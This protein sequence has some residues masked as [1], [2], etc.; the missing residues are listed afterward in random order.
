MTTNKWLKFLPT[1][2]CPPSKFVHAHIFEY[3]K[4]GKFCMAML[5]LASIYN[6]LREISSSNSLSKCDASCE[7]L[8]FFFFFFFFVDNFTQFPNNSFGQFWVASIMACGQSLCMAMLVL[9]SIHN[10]LME[11][12]PSNSLS[13]CDASFLIHY[14]YM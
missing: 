8:N 4:V 13:K 3:V 12:S 9:A 14:V 5:V 2:K 7:F 11:I 10:G 1:Y 6:G